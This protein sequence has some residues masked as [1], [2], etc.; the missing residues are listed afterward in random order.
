VTWLLVLL[1]L[2]VVFVPWA[3]RRTRRE[4]EDR[5]RPGM[6]ARPTQPRRGAGHLGEAPV[7]VHH[8]LGGRRSDD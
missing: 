6:P 2:V 7:T 1:A 8:R 3:R 4:W 5:T